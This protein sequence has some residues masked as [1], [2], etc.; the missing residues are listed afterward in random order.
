MMREN[1]AD[2]SNKY[3]PGD[4]TQVPHCIGADS[5]ILGPYLDHP[6]CLFEVLSLFTS[7][8]KYHQ[9]VLPTKQR[10]PTLIILDS[11]QQIHRDNLLYVPRYGLSLQLTEADIDLNL[12]ICE[13]DDR[14]LGIGSGC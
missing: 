13:S 3:G 5:P 8:L 1:L 10:G 6:Q 11:I 4:T 2:L 7:E 12:L 14:Y 9:V